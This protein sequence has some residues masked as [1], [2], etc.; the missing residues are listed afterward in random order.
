MWRL[1]LYILGGEIV[2]GPLAANQPYEKDGGIETYRNAVKFAR[3]MKGIVGYDV[4]WGQEDAVK[5]G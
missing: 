2:S 1:T 5:Q 3:K 4:K